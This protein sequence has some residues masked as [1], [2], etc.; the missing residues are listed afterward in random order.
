MVMSDGASSFFLKVSYQ[1]RDDAFNLELNR[2]QSG[3]IAP[4]EMKD[5]V[6]EFETINDEHQRNF[7]IQLD[8]NS[9]NL[10]LYA[11]KCQGELACGFFDDRV[12]KQKSLP[13][14]TDIKMNE[15]PFNPK[16][17][18]VT[19][20]CSKSNSYKSIKMSH[21]LTIYRCVMDIGVYSNEVNSTNTN[22]TTFTLK[23]QDKS[24][25][26]NLPTNTWTQY[27]VFPDSPIALQVNIHRKQYN[28]YSFLEFFF[29][30]HYGNAKII[31]SKENK[32]P[33]NESSTLT[34]REVGP[35]VTS[36]VRVN[37]EDIPDKKLSGAYYICIKPSVP[38]SLVVTA[39]PV[40]STYKL[41]NDDPM[42][43][44]VPMLT[45]NH[46]VLGELPSNSKDTL[47]FG[48]S[49]RIDFKDPQSVK[50]HV[51]PIRGK[52]RW[53]VSS[54]GKRPNSDQPEWNT[55]EKT[56]EIL[57]RRNQFDREGMYVIGV[58]LANQN[59]ATQNGLSNKF[60]I[61]FTFGDKHI[62]LRKGVPFMGESTIDLPH[63]YLHVSFPIST[64][65]NIT[66]FRTSLQRYTNLFFSFNQSVAYPNMTNKDAIMPSFYSAFVLKKE[67]WA[68]HC[69][70]SSGTNDCTLFIN[71]ASAGPARY[72]IQYSLN[73]EPI[74]IPHGY[75]FSI[76]TINDPGF[77]LK[78]IYHIEKHGGA[79]I[80]MRP[81]FQNIR[82]YVSWAK[83][84]SDTSKYVFPSESSKT[85]Q[86]ITGSSAFQPVFTVYHNDSIIPED[87]EVLLFTLYQDVPTA[88]LGLFRFPTHVQYTY[89]GYLEVSS[90]SKYLVAG[91]PVTATSHYGEWKFYKLRHP[92]FGA[93]DLTIHVEMIS[94]VTEV[95]VSKGHRKLPSDKFY[96]KKQHDFSEVALHISREDLP[97]DVP[98]EGDYMVGV[99]CST[100]TASYQILYEQS[101]SKY[102]TLELGVPISY[103]ISAT[104]PTFIEIPSDGVSEDIFITFHSRYAH[105]KLLAIARKL[106]NQTDEQI[107]SPVLPNDENYMWTAEQENSKAGFGRMV[108]SKRD[109][110]YCTMCTIII[111]VQASEDDKIDFTAVK[112]TSFSL[113]RIVEGK[114]Y[115]GDLKKGENETFAMVVPGNE[116]FL[117]INCRI[118]KGN[119][120]F[121]YSLDPT[122]TNSA[123]QYV[124]PERIK[125][126][127]F[128]V[129]FGHLSTF[130]RDI[131][132]STITR[133][134]RLEA[135][136]DDSQYS[137]TIV[138]DGMVTELTTLDSQQAVLGLGAQHFYY[139]PVNQNETVSV[140]FHLRSVA[141][142]LDADFQSIVD[143]LTS[144][145]TF[146]QVKTLKEVES[147]SYD[148]EIPTRYN[149]YR[150]ELQVS[151]RPNK[152]FVVAVIKSKAN[153]AISYELEL[154]RFGV[155]KL[156]TGHERP[157]FVEK[158]MI[159]HYLVEAK[160]ANHDAKVKF[161][162]CL[163]PIH[164]HYTYVDRVLSHA[165][166]DQSSHQESPVTL[167]SERYEMDTIPIRVDKRIKVTV[168]QPSSD[169]ENGQSHHTFYPSIF[170]IH[171][172]IV[173]S[174][175]ARDQKLGEFLVGDLKN[176]GEVEVF[177]D[178]DQNVKF[179]GLQFHED[180]LR[181]H[182][183]SSI[184]INY[185]LYISKD[186]K[187]LTFMKHCDYYMIDV[188]EEAL[189]SNDYY[190]YSVLEYHS[191]ALDKKRQQ[192]PVLSLKPHALSFG[193]T[194]HGVIVAE[195]RLWPSAVKV[196][197]GN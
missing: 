124:I 26:H 7:T 105:I 110:N 89:N 11:R 76:P 132:S 186:K 153:M 70:S 43:A 72:A 133:F 157:D 80:E 160:Q 148:Y 146:Y 116:S 84:Q 12:V 166:K 109:T 40:V 162:T 172:D 141:N 60:L 191:L 6:L 180:F 46:Q 39:N 48:I 119:I 41:G 56:L 104:Q 106:E 57:P 170:R 10:Y 87:M 82:Y 25:L 140:F 97:Y 19:F 58:Q 14:D 37:R 74:I 30:V 28:I 144:M 181:S 135:L 90:D 183:E 121:V 147:R 4:A 102:L 163:N 122:F 1:G 78:L 23:I 175:G 117:N 31:F 120:T 55:V 158:N 71:V 177:S 93:D 127:F 42:L 194:F 36:I 44:N 101:S 174:S 118:M 152:G 81:M 68:K 130:M 176:Y 188:A 62:V 33:C 168:E 161:E 96:L 167:V 32:N 16:Y 129:N 92:G 149:L 151:M 112:K 35:F 38:I 196:W 17:L 52:F 138:S 142:I 99:R 86:V 91:R 155:T 20:P 53:F 184:L 107:T 139:F 8:S 95:Y 21:N 193:G 79:E 66:I 47:Y 143:R 54:N 63:Q 3:I 173:P 45:P 29:D 69:N 136:E 171:H 190:S 49:T 73:G 150:H 125:D 34:S 27:K 100:P 154:S 134:I 94:G 9:R 108:I 189:N 88:I 85:P 126:E 103:K 114:T 98:Y 5:F 156:Q 165:K 18:E 195:V 67:L 24:L 182:S 123:R 113:I 2:P 187:M 169:L 131:F 185:T 111:R 51:T 75:P 128:N 179:E 83:E 164:A 22:E 192:T 13:D 145:I 65:E 197:I 77:P 115:I 15:T 61:S 178:A 64:T 59:P 137:F 159:K 50:I